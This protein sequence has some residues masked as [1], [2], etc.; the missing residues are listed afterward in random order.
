MSRSVGLGLSKAFL[1]SNDDW[2]VCAWEVNHRSD[3]DSLLLR[4]PAY[5]HSIRGDATAYSREVSHEDHEILA[6]T[7]WRAVACSRGSFQGGPYGRKR[8]AQ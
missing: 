6:D 2:N 3:A 5:V 4:R 7:Q 1:K 8:M